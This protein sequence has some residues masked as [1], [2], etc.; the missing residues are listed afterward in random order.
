LYG[1]KS[2]ELHTPV[3]IS[4]KKPGKYQVY[5]LAISEGMGILDS[6]VQYEEMITLALKN[7]GPISI[8]IYSISLCL[9]G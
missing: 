2:F 7:G 5:V 6:N 3:T 1:N 9:Q 8:G 4:V